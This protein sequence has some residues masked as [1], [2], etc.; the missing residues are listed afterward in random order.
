MTGSKLQL[1]F[2]GAENSYLTKNPEIT[3]FKAVYRNI[4][5]FGMQSIDLQFEDVKMLDYN[6]STTYKLIFNKNGDLLN[7]IFFRINLPKI[8][9]NN[10]K[11]V[12][13]IGEILIKRAKII[14]G[15]QIIEDYDGEYIHILNRLS[16]SKEKNNLLDRLTGKN[17]YKTNYLGNQILTIPLPFWFHRNIGCSLPL[18]NLLYHDVTIEIELRPINQIIT[19]INNS[20][21]INNNNFLNIFEDST[22]NIDAKIDATYIFLDNILK[23]S[24]EKSDLQYIVE[25]VMIFKEKNQSGHIKLE[26]N[27]TAALP[28]HQ[29]KEIYILGRRNDNLEFLNFTNNINIEDLYSNSRSN[30]TNKDLLFYNNNIINNIEIKF[31]TTY[32]LDKKDGDYFTLI[33]PYLH[34]KYNIKGLYSYSFSLNP[35]KFQPSGKCNFSHI[36]KISLLIDLKNP[37]DNQK[38]YK[39]DLLIYFRYYN[40]LQI[41]GGMGDL[42]FRT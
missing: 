42:L 40:I 19:N 16:Q 26:E 31:N 13:N 21:N 25:P 12:P 15:G 8:T 2:K 38:K 24:F 6:K 34:H 17:I 39:Y 30:M 36:E 23:D 9:D 32:R 29:C 5:N 7:K 22:W 11:W 1:Q 35:D 20:T 41:R 33:Q 3:F 28:R 27:L 10:Y 37:I 4:H 18:N 14:I